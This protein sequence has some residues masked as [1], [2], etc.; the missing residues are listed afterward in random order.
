MRFIS[1]SWDIGGLPSTCLSLSLSERKP[2]GSF[3]LRANI[4]EKGDEFKRLEIRL[5]N[6]SW[7]AGRWVSQSLPTPFVAF[8]NIFL[9]DWTK[10]SL[11][12]FAEAWR[13]VMNL[14]SYP[15]ASA[16]AFV[17]EFLNSVPLSLCSL[18]GKPMIENTSTSVRTIVSDFLSVKGLMMQKRVHTSI[19]TMK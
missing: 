9:T 7:I 1:S 13:G 2:W 18:V 14:W 17:R 16:S 4:N 5:F 3:I 6:A 10:R 8:A 15:M 11:K 19:I 12:P